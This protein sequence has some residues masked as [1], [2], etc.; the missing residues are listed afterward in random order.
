MLKSC[1]FTGI[2]SVLGVTS[3]HFLETP[4]GRVGELKSA[5][6]VCFLEKIAPV[7]FWVS[8][9]SVD[10]KVCAAIISVDIMSVFVIS[11]CL[12]KCINLGHFAVAA[13]CNIDCDF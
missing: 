7:R 5:R 2:D 9:F 8:T 12:S 4:G 1:T 11:N 13:D 10:D 3:T 6:S